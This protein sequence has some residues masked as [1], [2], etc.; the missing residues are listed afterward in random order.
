MAEAKNPPPQ[1]YLYHAEIMPVAGVTVAVDPIVA[2]LN[3]LGAE[4]WQLVCFT[5]TIAWFMKPS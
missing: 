2:R 3:E 5:G 4:G 1:L